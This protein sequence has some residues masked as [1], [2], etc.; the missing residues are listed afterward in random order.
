MQFGGKVFGSQF[1]NF[2]FVF[3]NFPNFL[4]D[5]VGKRLD[6]NLPKPEKY[7]E[8][9][10]LAYES[11]KPGFKTNTVVSSTFYTGKNIWLVKAIDL[12]RGRCIRIANEV[13]D[14]KR[15]IKNFYDGVDRSFKKEEQKRPDILIVEGS[16]EKDFSKKLKLKKINDYSKYRT[17]LVLLQKYLETPLLYYGR[18]FD[19]RI[20]V[21]Y[22]QRETVYAFK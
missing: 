6:P 7:G 13:S 21:L 16:P 8:M 14:I 11:D 1:N 4:V 15:I 2:T 17:S 18:K 10:K 9:F 19:I 22:T 12:N 5:S 3:N 20:W